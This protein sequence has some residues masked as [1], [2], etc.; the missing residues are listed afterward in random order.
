MIHIINYG[1]V[2][3]TVVYYPI[4]VHKAVCERACALVGI[5]MCACGYI[6]V[7]VC[8]RVR[9]GTC[10]SCAHAR[11]RVCVCVRACVSVCRRESNRLTHQ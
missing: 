11:V 4:L 7:C 5:Y 3:T 1:D 8:V 10:E 9:M 2:S 6:H